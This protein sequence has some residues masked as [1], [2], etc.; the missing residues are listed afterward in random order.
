MSKKYKRYNYDSNIEIPKTTAYRKNKK[1]KLLLQQTQQ[2]TIYQDINNQN[3]N[4]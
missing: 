3:V 1:Q 2:I 4:I